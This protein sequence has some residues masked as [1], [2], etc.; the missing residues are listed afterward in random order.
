MNNTVQPIR[1]GVYELDVRAG[2]LR[3]NGVRIKLQEKPFQVLKFL[4]ERPGEVITREEFQQR[5]WPDTF[6]DIEHSLS[7]AV[8]KLRDA[9]S[10][11]ADNPRFIETRPGRGY[12]FIYP[13]EGVTAKVPGQLLPRWMQVT[14]GVV[15]GILVLAVG[16][17]LWTAWT[18]PPLAA[19]DPL[20]IA[21]FVNRTGDEIFDGTLKTGLT[22]KME[23]SPYLAIVPPAQ[24]REVFQQMKLSSEEAIAE[25]QWREACLRL[26]AKAILSGE[27]AQIGAS[28]VL[29]IKASDCNTG[30]VLAGDQAEARTKEDVLNTLGRMSSYL[31]NSL[32]EALASVKQIDVPL[33]RA[34]TSSLEA[35]KAYSL[36]SRFVTDG[37]RPEAILHF[38]R[39]IELDPSFAIAYDYLAAAYN[40]VSDFHRAEEMA[41]RGFELRKGV[42]ER[43]RLRIETTYHYFTSG[44]SSKAIDTARLWKATYPHDLSA[45]NNLGFILFHSGKAEEAIPILEE[46]VQRNPQAE[47]SSNNLARAYTL[48]NRFA[49]AREIWTKKIQR[50][51]YVLSSHRRLFTLAFIEN[52]Q[53]LMQ[54]HADRVNEITG[55]RGMDNL[56]ANVA[57]VEGRFQDGI[58]LKE[59]IVDRSPVPPPV[60]LLNLA[61]FEAVRGRQAKAVA[62]VD[63]FK[64]T[65]GDV[66]PRHQWMT[67]EVALARAGK[68]ERALDVVRILTSKY[69]LGHA[70]NYVGA[71]TIRAMIAEQQGD[72]EKAIKFLSAS[73]PFDLSHIGMPNVYL[74]GLNLLKLK[75][76]KEAEAEF[77]KILVHPGINPYHITRPF[78]RLGLARAKMQMGE[79]DEAR[80][81]YQQFFELW[82]NADPDIPILLEA[83]A[84]YAKL[85]Q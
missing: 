12:R 30:A 84:E 81:V 24:V 52:D 40:S 42:T 23:E 10:D 41:T 2:E 4:L 78:A 58:A 69:P 73:E 43:E 35:L 59:G 80:R 31:R 29:T 1:F 75:R 64:K 55:G 28:Y 57:F 7:T 39:A 18:R 25:D 56:R 48:A 54:H 79:L 45:S 83:K 85:N 9:L 60:L 70:I 46:A 51:K 62:W 44:Q 74:R 15:L 21:D 38:Q 53:E 13:V 14:V 77:Q 32:G 61:L 47:I 26:G 68:H 5:I 66:A 33:E 49:D 67:A 76:G 71:A 82:K 11:S 20:L 34:T 8:K 36:G 22:I 50:Q 6:V 63:Q 16:V 19:G 3:K 65:H 27:I 37:K 17:F 72:S